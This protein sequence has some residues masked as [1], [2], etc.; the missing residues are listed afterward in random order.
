[1]I[2]NGKSNTISQAARRRDFL[3]N[4]NNY[5]NTHPAE[6]DN[7]AMAR[8]FDLT[9]SSHLSGINFSGSSQ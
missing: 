1:V 4:G 7:E 5:N 6:K 2:Y 9:G 3:A 8:S